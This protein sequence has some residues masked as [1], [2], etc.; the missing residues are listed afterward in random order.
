MK[1]EDIKRLQSSMEPIFRRN[2]VFKAVLFGSAVRDTETKRSD[3]D[4][5]IVM[6]TDKRFFDRY[7]AV[8]ERPAIYGLPDP[9]QCQP[10]GQAGYF[11]YEKELFNIASATNIPHNLLA[12]E[13]RKLGFKGYINVNSKSWT[14]HSVDN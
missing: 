9:L 4:L 7:D 1:P 14:K 10:G 8:S 2:E 11:V 6:E 12:A 13:A 3:I 5:M